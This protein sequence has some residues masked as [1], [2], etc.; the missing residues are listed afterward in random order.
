MAAD[1]NSLATRMRPVVWLSGSGSNTINAGG[2]AGV[3]GVGCATRLGPHPAKITAI[4]TRS[5]DGLAL[6]MRSLR[7]GVLRLDADGNGRTSYA[8]NRGRRFEADGIGSE[9]RDAS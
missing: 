7:S 4:V 3:G 1:P 8:D 6:D 9:L 2:V 5:A